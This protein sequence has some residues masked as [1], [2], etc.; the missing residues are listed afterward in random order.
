MNKDGNES[1]SR[2]NVAF[3]ETPEP[4]LL[5]E[6]LA[7]G[8]FTTGRKFP[9]RD[10]SHLLSC[11]MIIS[12][13]MCDLPCDKMTKLIIGVG[14]LLLYGDYCIVGTIHGEKCAMIVS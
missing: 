9:V 7:L 4:D 3:H 11:K 8:H 6:L 1:H 2:Q 10:K 13:S 14:R 5:T 12:D